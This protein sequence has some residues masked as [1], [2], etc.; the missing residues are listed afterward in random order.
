MRER[1]QTSGTLSIFYFN[2][3]DPRSF[4]YNAG[5]RRQQCMRY[6]VVSD[7]EVTNDFVPKAVN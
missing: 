1:C 7:T 3:H 6:F 5:V 2:W 4:G